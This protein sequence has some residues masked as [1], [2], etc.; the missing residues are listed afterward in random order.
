M[1]ERQPVAAGAVPP[2]LLANQGKHERQWETG[3]PGGGPA[4]GGWGGLPPRG[5]RREGG[6]Q[7]GGREGKEATMRPWNGGLGPTRRSVSL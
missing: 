7:G 4:K 5:G 3:L 6:R 2:T 1:Q